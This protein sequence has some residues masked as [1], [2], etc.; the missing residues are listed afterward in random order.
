M[1]QKFSP[2]LYLSDKAIASRCQ[3]DHPLPKY[4]DH[5]LD[6]LDAL[7]AIC[8]RHKGDVSLTVDPNYTT[9][10][11]STN[12]TVPA[13]LNAH[14]HKIQGQ[15][16]KLNSDAA[17]GPLTLADTIDFPDPNNTQSR[18]DGELGLQRII[19]EYS[20]QK[21]QRRFSKRGPGILDQYDDT[22]ASLEAN[23]VPE[24]SHHY[25]RTTTEN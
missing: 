16:K 13:T 17:S 2:E 11:V 1:A 5:L 21:V 8:V 3:S 6:V 15:L 24:D 20:Y 19:Y 10:H 23:N 18:M 14:L 22:M 25:V 7:A 12:G 9:L 4:P